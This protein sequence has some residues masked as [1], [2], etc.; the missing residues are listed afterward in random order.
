MHAD[1][2]LKP[3]YTKVLFFYERT[4]TN[5]WNCENKSNINY[6]M[7]ITAHRSIDGINSKPSWSIDPLE[8]FLFHGIFA[9][10][11]LRWNCG[12]LLLIYSFFGTLSRVCV[13]NTGSI[14]FEIRLH[15]C[16]IENF[17]QHMIRANTLLHLK[18]FTWLNA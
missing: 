17:I 11:I 13:K 7:G 16:W 8:F 4:I 12:N 15:R 10:I 18:L 5:N 14:W 9:N 3:K 6:R 1:I 2:Q